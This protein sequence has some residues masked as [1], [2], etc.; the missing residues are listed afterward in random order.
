MCVCVCACM[1]AC[2]YVSI[3][4]GG[5]GCEMFDDNLCMLILCVLLS[6]VLT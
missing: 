4:G 6:I 3:G 1:G 5:G 2:M